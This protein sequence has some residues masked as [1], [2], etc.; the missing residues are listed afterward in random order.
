MAGAIGTALGLLPATAAADPPTLAESLWQPE[1]AT[2]AACGGAYRL[3]AVPPVPAVAD[4]PASFQLTATTVATDAVGPAT[5]SGNVTVRHGERTLATERLAFDRRT[6]MVRTDAPVQLREPGLAAR[7]QRAT[8]STQP[9]RVQ[10]EDAEFVLAAPQ[11]RGVAAHVDRTD[12]ELSLAVTELTRCPPDRAP[13]R[14]T[15]DQ[16]RI[17]P[18][19]ASASVRGARLLLGRVPVFYSPYLR[20]PLGR[21]RSSGWLFP[22]ASTDDG[23]DLRLPYYM[24][25]A[26]NYDATVAPRWNRRRGAGADA[27]VR[28]LSPRSETLLH[29][30]WIH[31]DKDYD[32][33]ASRADFRTA[34]GAET[35]FAPADRYLL[36][37][38]HRGSYGRLA[39]AI[40]FTGVSDNDYFVDLGS[41]LATTGRVLLERRAELRYADR[42]LLARLWLQDFQRLEPGPAPYRRLP[43]ASLV[44]GGQLAGP[45]AW[46]IGGSWAAFE[47]TGMATA[48]QPHPH[49]NRL[50]LE[51]A[52]QLPLLRPWG[53]LTL[54]AKLRHTAYAL[55]AALP[56]S[57]RRP[58]RSVAA[59]RADGGLFLERPLAAGGTHTLEPRWQYRYQ[60]YAEQADLPRFDS[61]RLTFS[62]RQLFRE[63]R[64]AGVD[65]LGDANELAV[66]AT[67]RLLNDRGEERLAASLGAIAYFAD[68]RVVLA[69][70]PGPAQRTGTS[71]LAGE[72]RGTF[73]PLQAT[74]VL[75]WDPHANRTDLASIELGYRP[76]RQRLL[77]VGYRRRLPEAGA[78]Q[79]IEE[80][81]LSVA[82][83]FTRHWAAYGRWNH[84]WHSGQTIETL[85]GV[86]Y[87]SCCLEV[88]LLWH[89]TVA[90]PRNRLAA[91]AH[92]RRGVLVQF[93]FRGLAGFGG[94]VDGRLERSIRG[95]RRQP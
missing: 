10:L 7:G 52:L 31:R 79:R 60:S 73:G 41:D 95:Y 78:G 9:N 42:A 4:Q 49:G 2:F 14:L 40:D 18:A 33:T 74:A 26:P 86:G 36:G 29:G 16:I 88:K 87:A 5:A 45:L 23:F 32:G 46:R 89:D 85:A 84:D 8:F 55:P 67:T 28:H 82:W 93:V 56:D 54:D 75:A 3:P 51:P 91:D 53:F 47:R 57:Q 15:A 17:E 92:R 30:A 37:V 65:R 61:G 22:S 80:T 83:P 63:D 72:L 68:R 69:G 64:Y 62:Y 35:E 59:L 90:A 38:R 20:V 71:A 48:A 94:N 50:H 76:G 13:W 24:N 39:S 1:E 25:L 21:E 44:Y 34:G 58:S 27:E 12:A 70:V 6:R 81:D 66:G 77:N 19:A 43:E 11:L